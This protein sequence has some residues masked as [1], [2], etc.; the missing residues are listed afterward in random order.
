[1]VQ[2]CC[3]VCQGLVKSFRLLYTL[4][5]VFMGTLRIDVLRLDIRKLTGMFCMYIIRSW[6]FMT[7]IIRKGRIPCYSF[8]GK[9]QKV[10]RLKIVLKKDT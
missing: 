5:C 4:N 3:K 10:L 7:L 1:M 2:R 6:I 9:V 8:Q